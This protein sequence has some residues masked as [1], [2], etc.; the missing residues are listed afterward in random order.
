VNTNREVISDSFL[1]LSEI[2]I[3]SIPAV[4]PFTTP[5][6]ITVDTSKAPEMATWA[7]ETARLCELWYSRIHDALASDGFKPP[8]QIQ[9]I[10][11][12]DY[13][14]VAM[15]SGAKITGAVKW[16]KAHPRDVG[17]MIHETVHVVQAYRRF[18]GNN[19]PSWLVE[20][21][22]DHFRFFTFEPGN[23]GRID[24]DP[25]YNKSYRTT[26]AFLAYVSDKYEKTLVKK[27]NAAIRNGEYRE[28]M[29]KDLTGKSL[30]ELDK[31]WRKSL[32][33]E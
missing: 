26:A 19:A 13:N 4:I 32:G 12:P 5:V 14:G 11:T 7:E 33:K 18:R 29:F 23:L 21:I 28:T 10:I 15:A 22:A 9:M 31:E 6:E 25:H 27:L 30:D 1:K 17:A 24:P 20:G 3:E 8:R 2:T 16:F